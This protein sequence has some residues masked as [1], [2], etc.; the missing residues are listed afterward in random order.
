MGLLAGKIFSILGFYISL[1]SLIPALLLFLIK[2]LLSENLDFLKQYY[3]LP[4]SLTGFYLL[5]TV[6]YGGL[7]L[8]LSS[9][10]KGARFAGF[11]CRGLYVLFERVIIIL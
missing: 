11:G 3:W 1:I 4:F 10:G 7:I 5:I 9:R 8:A 2:I 6:V